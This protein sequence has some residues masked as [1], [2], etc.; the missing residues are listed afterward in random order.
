MPIVVFQDGDRLRG[1]GLEGVTP[2]AE[3]ELASTV[4]GDLRVH[5]KGRIIAPVYG[6]GLG[7]AAA[8]IVTLPT[9][10]D[11]HFAG[12]AGPVYEGRLIA[13]W[14]HRR[15]GAAA[16][17]GVRIRQ[18]H[19]EKFLAPQ[20]EFG[21]ELVWGAGIEAVIPFTPLRALFE[22]VGVETQIVGSG[23]SPGEM[24]LGARYRHGRALVF[25][26]AGGV[27]FGHEDDVGAPDMRFILEA[28]W[29]PTPRTD[30]DRDGVPDFDDRCP[31]EQEDRDGFLD[32]DGCIDADDDDDGIPDTKDECRT[33]AEDLDKYADSDGC[34]ELDN[35]QDGIPDPRD[36]CPGDAEDKDG[37]ADN[38][39]CIDRDNDSDGVLD[40]NDKCVDQAEDK[41]GVEDEDGCPD[42]D[43]DQDKIPDLS[44]RCPNEVEDP[45]GFRDEDGCPDTDDDRDGVAD[46]V[47]KCLDRAETVSS[48][49]DRNDDGCPDGAALARAADGKIVLTPAAAQALAFKA[50]SAQISAAGNGVV[51]AIARAALRAGWDEAKGEAL[52]VTAYGDAG[53]W[54]ELSQKRSDALVAA[55]AKE[56]IKA[57]IDTQAPGAAKSIAITA[58]P[59]AVETGS[60]IPVRGAK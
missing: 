34:P 30:S 48:T 15:F 36:K 53:Q 19:V 20:L 8:A 11:E 10:N 28:R 33:E 49:N 21:N 39:G 38:D 37:F 41:D 45:D 3:D 22:V 26:A 25:G 6:L 56:G 18:T 51:R 42:G 35:D 12:E 52:V 2:D 1:L 58:T 50:G 9:G 4:L 14:R 46:G 31:T 29:E 17:A 5:L 60:Q 54:D 16:N 23:P 40:E 55:L 59:E 13:S 27:G 43:N 44:D 7:V 24:R 57:R 32:G 47:D